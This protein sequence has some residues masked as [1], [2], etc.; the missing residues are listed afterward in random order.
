MHVIDIAPGCQLARGMLGA[1]EIA[2]LE[3]AYAQVLTRP[4]PGLHAPFPGA[5]DPLDRYPRIMQPHRRPDHPAGALALRLL[6]DQRLQ[7]AVAG[8]MGEPP[9]AIQSMYYFKPPGSR[10]QAFHQDNRYA[11]V[12]PGTCWAAWIAVDP[13]SQENGCLRVSPGSGDAPLQAET[14]DTDTTRYAYGMGVRRPER[15]E[16]MVMDAGDVLF[17]NGQ[18]VHGSEPNTST[19]FR[20]SLILHYAPSSCTGLRSRFQ[21]ALDPLGGQ[22][23][24]GHGGDGGLVA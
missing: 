19:R 5:S 17:F 1:C 4:D 23:L 14:G 22:V 6:L 2:E 21:P 24:R 15:L 12:H 16:A 3:D 13:C 11:Q 20:R 8:A 9:L 10:G 7:G 18:L